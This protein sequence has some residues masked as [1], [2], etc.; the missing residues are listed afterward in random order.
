MTPPVLTLP[1]EHDSRAARPP[2]YPEI[3]RSKAT[4]SP[5]TI[6][7][8]AET[9]LFRRREAAE[10]LREKYGVGSASLLAKLAVYGGGPRFRKFNARVVLYSEADIDSWMADKLGTAVVSTSQE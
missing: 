4:H 6:P 3:V 10:Y 9:R 5:E 2:N 7:V 1:Q 8:A